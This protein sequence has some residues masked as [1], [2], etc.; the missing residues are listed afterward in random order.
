MVR[1]CPPLTLRCPRSPRALCWTRVPPHPELPVLCGVPRGPVAPHPFPEPEPRPGCPLSLLPALDVRPGS[2]SC[3]SAHGFGQGAPGAPAWSEGTT[4][5]AALSM[6]GPESSGDPAGGV[7]LGAQGC[8]A[9]ARDITR[10]GPPGSPGLGA[11]HH[12]LEFEVSEPLCKPSRPPRDD[13]WPG[14]L[15]GQKP[16]RA[17]SGVP[18]GQLA[19]RL[20]QRCWGHPAEEEEEQRLGV[21][22]APVQPRR[23]ARPRREGPRGVQGRGPLRGPRGDPVSCPPGPQS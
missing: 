13:F 22:C 6:W 3:P 5:Q 9:S 20:A 15:C 4:E 17:R 11:A 12:G 1:P 2:A 10:S 8:A 14:R 19:P 16:P 7:Q 18:A 23:A 21:R